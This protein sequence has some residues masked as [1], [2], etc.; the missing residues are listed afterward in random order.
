MALYSKTKLND[1]IYID[2]YVAGATAKKTSKENHVSPLHICAAVGGPKIAKLLIDYEDVLIRMRNSE[3][4]IPLHKAAQYGRGSVTR[5]LIERYLHVKCAIV[6]I[7]G[8]KQRKGR[9]ILTKLQ[10]LVSV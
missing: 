7:S 5:I 4:M 2:L 1:I 3:Q 6:I 10:P 9:T 8:Y